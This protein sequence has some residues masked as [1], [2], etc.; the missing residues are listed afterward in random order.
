MGLPNFSRSKNLIL[1]LCLLL[2]G[3]LCLQAL[4]P[5]TSSAAPL[6]Q[7]KGGEQMGTADATAPAGAYAGLPGVASGQAYAAYLTAN[8]SSGLT[9][10]GPLYGAALGCNTTSTNKVTT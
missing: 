1:Q 10:V 5:A 8:N 9:T 2:I 7:E 6:S 3:L 4:T